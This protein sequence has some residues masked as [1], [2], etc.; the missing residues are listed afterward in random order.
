[1]IIKNW[2]NVLL[3]E[4]LITRTDTFP[5]ATFSTKNNKHIDWSGIEPSLLGEGPATLPEPFVDP[6]LY[7]YIYY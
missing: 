1:M 5:R 6:V 7:T 3:W 2:Y 4:N